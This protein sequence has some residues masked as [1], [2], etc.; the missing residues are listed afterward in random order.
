[1]LFLPSYSLNLI[2]RLWK[3]VKKEVLRRTAG[4]RLPN[5]GSREGLGI[6]VEMISH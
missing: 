5:W 3:F 1:M 4:G 2:E 6:G